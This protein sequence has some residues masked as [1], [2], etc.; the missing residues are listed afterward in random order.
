MKLIV[1]TLAALFLLMG[2]QQN[3]SHEFNDVSIKD[4]EGNVLVTS[5]DFEKASIQDGQNRVLVNV[6]FK[7]SDT[8][9]EMTENHLNEKVHIYLGD[10]KIASPTVRKVI[11]SDSMQ[12]AGDYTK[13]EAEQFVDF[14][15]QS[16]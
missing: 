4:Q 13:E 5:S 12:V 15:N 8:P 9:K 11:H 7:N 6:N 2:C 10:E 1:S 14:I 16:F 3:V